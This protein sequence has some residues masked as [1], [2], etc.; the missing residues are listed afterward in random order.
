M[1]QILEV[2]KLIIVKLLNL[3]ENFN[4]KGGHDIYIYDN[5]NLNAT[6]NS[7]LGDTYKHPK[8]LFHSKEAKSFLAGSFTFQTAEI[9]VYCKEFST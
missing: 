3:I 1:D 2:N 9:E 5:S 6:S 4:N 8:Y 7:N